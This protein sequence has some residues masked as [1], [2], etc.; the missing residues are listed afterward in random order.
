MFEE[1]DK[2]RDEV[3]ARGQ[4]GFPDSQRKNG[5]FWSFSFFFFLFFK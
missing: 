2:D 4:E 3:R 5:G 1:K